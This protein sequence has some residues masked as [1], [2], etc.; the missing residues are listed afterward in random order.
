MRRAAF[1]AAFRDYLEK[2]EPVEGLPTIGQL[3][4]GKFHS[5]VSG[6]LKHAHC[7]PEVRNLKG[8]DLTYRDEESRQWKGSIYERARP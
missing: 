2:S 6:A 3:I 4:R 1:A 8:R 5:E 7:R